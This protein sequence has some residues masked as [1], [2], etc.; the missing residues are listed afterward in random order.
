M[1]IEVR[2]IGVLEELAGTAKDEI[3]VESRN[4]L[5]LKELMEKYIL[6]LHPSLIIRTTESKDP[7]TQFT[8]A[9]NGKLVHDLNTL[10][11]DGDIVLLMIP[12]AGG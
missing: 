11:K 3:F 9:V 1:R 2:Y 6:T 10:L 5:T 7:V 4:S 12:I 8:I